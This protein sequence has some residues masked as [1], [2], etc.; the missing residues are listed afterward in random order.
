[1]GGWTDTC[2]RTKK[3]DLNILTRQDGLREKNGGTM[4]Q[5]QKGQ[6]TVPFIW[7]RKPVGANFSQLSTKR[8]LIRYSD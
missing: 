7:Q 3:Y 5:V 8:L 1:M 6:K 2:F 4:L